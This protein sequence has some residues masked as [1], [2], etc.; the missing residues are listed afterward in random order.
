MKPLRRCSSRTEI[1]KIIVG[2][3]S[4]L[5]PVNTQTVQETRNCKMKQIG[6]KNRI[7]YLWSKMPFSAFLAEL[8]RDSD[9]TFNLSTCKHQ[10][11]FFFEKNINTVLR[12]TRHF[13]VDMNNNRK[14]WLTWKSIY[15]TCPGKRVI[16]WWYE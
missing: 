14:G 10:K 1:I 16:I 15:S 11:N 12:E 4:N 8:A 3:K 7:L 13:P 5:Q 2:I 9:K 6:S